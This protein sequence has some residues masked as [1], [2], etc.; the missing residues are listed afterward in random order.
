MLRYMLTAGES[1]IKGLEKV[2]KEILPA[3]GQGLGYVDKAIKP[4]GYP[5]STDTESTIEIPILGMFDGG[6]ERAAMTY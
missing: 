1:I 6:D 4:L 5:T 2:S 3:D